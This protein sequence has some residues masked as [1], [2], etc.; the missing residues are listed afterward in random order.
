M[1]L[2]FPLALGLLVLGFH[3]W[4]QGVLTNE[5]IVTFSK[6]NMSERVMEQLVHTRAG[7]YDVTP[8]ALISLKEAGVPDVVIAA[9]VN[10]ES[11]A[12]PMASNYESQPSNPPDAAQ[13][14]PTATVQLP[15]SNAPR[16]AEGHAYRFRSSFSSVVLEDATPVSLRVTTAASSETA[17]L[18][19]AMTFQVARAVTVNGVVVIPRGAKATGTIASVKHKG[20]M[21][22]G[23]IL[24][25]TIDSVTLAD[26]TEVPLRASREGPTASRSNTDSIAFT[27]GTKW[28]A[29]PFLILQ[30]RD[31]VIPH[32]AQVTGYVDGDFTVAKQDP[33][34]HL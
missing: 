20:D 2:S 33:G 1:R 19:D 23:G 6:V 26:G 14:F 12:T 4:A 18:G 8:N 16:A 31:A 15:L 17:K 10:H 24:Q 3:A 29:T 9:M 21:G 13:M 5:T 34:A 32:G 7:K 28:V 30:G 11:S 22:R 25:L 27:A